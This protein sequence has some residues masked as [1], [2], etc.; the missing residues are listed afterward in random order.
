MSK[1]FPEVDAAKP[2]RLLSLAL[3]LAAAQPST[4]QSVTPVPRLDLK[5]FSG[6][7]YEI[8]RYP[9]KR[10]KT[11]IGDAFNLIAAGDK[12]NR[13]LLVASCKTRTTYPN[14]RNANLR[15]QDKS[16]DGKLKLSFTWPFSSK[17]WVLALGPD[18]QW[19]LIGS[20]NRKNLWIFS[21]SAT[22]KPDILAE[23]ESQ[24]AAQGFSSAKL[25]MTPQSARF[26]PPPTPPQ[27]K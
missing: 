17:Y 13:L 22:L 24:A 19:S 16:G 2:I 21:R 8:A 18:Y 14:V 4:A 23:I 12:P 11:C 3:L 5:Q 10:E 15:S 7:W 1:R 25:V 27:S 6:T 26:T 20:P 9:L